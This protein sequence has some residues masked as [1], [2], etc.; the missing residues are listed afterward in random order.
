MTFAILGF[1]IVIILSLLFTRALGEDKLAP[2][3][4]GWSIF[5]FVMVIG[6]PLM[7]LQLGVIWGTFAL[8]SS[9]DTPGSS[10]VAAPP[11]VR[12]PSTPEPS[13]VIEPPVPSVAQPSPKQDLLARIAAPRPDWL[14]DVKEVDWDKAIRRLA[15]RSRVEERTI[16]SLYHFTQVENLP[17]I[18]RRGLLPPATLQNRAIPFR[19]ND[20]HR[21]D[22]HEDAVS[23]SIGHP[24]ELLFYKWRMRSPSQRWCV[25]VLS[26]ELLWTHDVAFYP[27]NAADHRMSGLERV[28][29]GDVAS[30]DQLFA[31]RDG[32][33]DRAAQRLLP[34]DPTDVQAEVLLFGT[35]PPSHIKAAVFSDPDTLERSKHNLGTRSLHMHP[36]RTGVFGRRHVLRQIS[37]G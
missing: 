20:A 6:S 11:P 26:A 27:R 31:E 34:S 16:A 4:V 9:S 22:G 12:S 29:R 36:Q 7:L 21:L 2:V 19:W 35:I 10:T 15:V 32:L 37:E 8:L 33:P 28:A 5:T 14:V 24:N 3:C 30:F 1:Q 17:S 13:R 23:L 25:L 18:M